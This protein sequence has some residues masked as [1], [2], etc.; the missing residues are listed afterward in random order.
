MFGVFKFKLLLSRLSSSIPRMVAPRF[1]HCLALLLPATICRAADATNSS[2]PPTSQKSP[3]DIEGSPEWVRRAFQ[4]SNSSA[5]VNLA[6]KYHTGDGVPKDDKKAIR[7]FFTAAEVGDSAAERNLGAVYINGMGVP[8]DN[9]KALDWII[10]AGKDGDAQAQ[11][12]L[13]RIYSTEF[14]GPRDFAKA[15][16]WTAASATHAYPPAEARL[17]EMYQ[18]G[19]GVKSDM[20]EALKW[21]QLAVDAENKDAIPRRDEV[22]SLLDPAQKEEAKRR[23]QSFKPGTNYDAVADDARAV[24]CSLGS[25]FQIPVKIFGETNFM[26]V[27]TGSSWAVLDAGYRSR[28]GELM[29]LSVIIDTAASE[30]NSEFR[31]CPEIY[32]GETRFA[33]LLAAVLDLETVRQAL[34]EP[35]RGIFGLSCLKYEVVCFD[36]DHHAFTIGGSVPEAVKQK[37]QAL[38]LLFK[39]NSEF[40]VEAF[41]NGHG[42][43][44]LM[45]DSGNNGSISLNKSDWRKVFPS[46]TAKSRLEKA[47]DLEGKIVGDSSA[48]LQSVTIGTNNYTNLI[49]DSLANP[50]LPSSFGQEFIQRHLCYVDFPNRLLYLLPGHD[51]DRPEE[52]DMSGLHLLKIDGKIAVNYIDENAP[53]YR[54]G[55]RADD[56]ILSINGADAA[57]LHLKSIREMLKTKPGDEIKMQIK[58][59]AQTNS[60]TFRLK[61]LL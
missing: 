47:T 33:P 55:I 50:E 51:F 42:P 5:V 36:S 22:A 16:V 59:G 24:T 1:L 20:V 28:L 58:H 15:F 53:G 38:P 9:A 13:G 40:C 39:D 45:M 18:E 3:A 12:D 54:A 7:L 29:T 4:Q 31:E 37:A 14:A 57:S 35:I 26:V 52:D 49:A 10:A 44:L 32:I 60:V 21:L 11:F 30:T 46:R 48:R 34:G 25:D 6:V 8:R 17:G 19:I 23:A 61:R 43:I 27:D 2:P 41:I 56:Q